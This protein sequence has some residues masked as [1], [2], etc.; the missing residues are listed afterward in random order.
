MLRQIKIG[1]LTPKEGKAKTKTPFIVGAVEKIKI[2][3]IHENSDDMVTKIITADGEVLVENQGSKDALFYPRNWNTQNQKYTGANI[4]ADGQNAMSAERYICYGQLT[5]EAFT[6]PSRKKGVE[7]GIKEIIILID[8][9]IKSGEIKKEMVS[10]ATPGVFNPSH[11]RR[12][13]IVERYAKAFITKFNSPEL[14]KAQD[15]YKLLREF[16]LTSIYS[17]RFQGMKKK[18]SDAIKDYIIKSLLYKYKPERILKYIMRKGETDERQ[19]NLI[20][21]TEN[22]ALQNKSR[23]WAYMKSDPEGTDKYKWIGPKDSRTTSICK[24][25][26]K[27]TVNGVEMEKLKE[28][29]EDEVNRAKEEG[30]LPKDYEQ[31]EFCPHF[32]CRHTMI[33]VIK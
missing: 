2:N 25:I 11:R 6:S 24:R 28:I 7:D 32:S 5:I 23:E 8:G 29:I 10:T 12:K 16:L 30:I 31:R 19:A 26:T 21:R 3:Y 20:F 15:S 14:A 18:T 13:N 1:K 27:R 4:A 33:K 17:H 22:N 9:E